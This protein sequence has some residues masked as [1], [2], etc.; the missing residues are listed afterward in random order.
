MGEHTTTPQENSTRGFPAWLIYAIGAAIMVVAIVYTTVF[1]P[2]AT[3]T[4][5]TTD[6]SRSGYLWDEGAPKKVTTAW[7]KEGYT[8]LINTPGATIVSTNNSVQRINPDNGEALWEYSRRD[9][10]VCDIAQAWGD[11]VAV[12]NTGKG[13]TDITRLDSATGEYMR[14]ASYATD[15]DQARMVFGGDGHLAVVTPKLVRVLRD[16]LVTTA[17]FGDKVDYDNP[18]S[19]RNCTIYDASIGPKAFTVAS[20]CFG[21][22]TTHITALEIEPE[23]STNPKVI[24]DVDTKVDKPATTPI[25]TLAQMQFITQTSSPSIYTW[26]LDKGK[27]EVTSH[28]SQQGEYGWGSWDYPGIGYVWLIGDTLRV[29][30]GSEDVSQSTHEMTGISGYPVEADD[31]ILAPTYDGFVLWDTHNE[32]RHNIKVDTP[33]EGRKMSLAGDTIIGFHDGVIRAYR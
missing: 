30:Y 15:Q 28:P 5:T 10:T 23:D 7:E 16:D 17:E 27:S 3:T 12:F 26:Q 20:K 31:K 29:R 33:F 6:E 19:I 4:L 11:V 9:A 13:C 25:T 14:Q 2:A 21:D 32:S 24:V 18:E 22:D 8:N 1:S